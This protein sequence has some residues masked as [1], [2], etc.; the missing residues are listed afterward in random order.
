VLFG[1]AETQ[2]AGTFANSDVRGTYAG[3]TPT[4]TREQALVAIRS[5]AKRELMPVNVAEVP[6]PR[7]EFVLPAVNK[8]R[9]ALATS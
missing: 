8:I 3:F 5:T 6:A 4:P 7:G 2:A 1:F 9:L